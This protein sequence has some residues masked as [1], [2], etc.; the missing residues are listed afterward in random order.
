MLHSMPR[1]LILCEFPTLNGGERSLL[2]ALD[3][4]AAVEF[5]VGVIAPEEGPLAAAVHERGWELIPFA[6]RCGAGPRK[7]AAA[8]RGELRALALH[9]APAVIHANSLAMGRLLGPVA[10]ELGVPSLAHLRDIIG[11]SAQA[12]CDLNLNGRL[13]A[14]SHATRDFHLGQ[15]L[16]AA[17]TRV[18]Y[19]GVDLERFCPRPPTGALHCELGLPADAQLIGT[20]GQI[21]LRKGLDVLVAAAERIAPAIPRAHWVIVGERSS[22]KDES[23]RFEADL[24]AAAAEGPLAGRLHLLGRRGDVPALLCEW[25]MLVHAARQEPLGRVLLEA[26]ATGVPIAATAVGGTREIFPAECGAARLVPAGD[27]AAL[28]EAMAALLTDAELRRSLSQA[29]R[30]RAEA[31]FDIRTAAEGL[32]RHYAELADRR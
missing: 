30:R 25:T 23:R 17:K 9:R 1:L 3:A 11:L 18:L 21:G 6:T 27:A 10:A 15:G 13:L 22:D 7:S 16:D 5:E 24:R 29:A 32:R 20:V 14:V 19:N 4:G 8:L 12:V 2:A 31:Q 28:A 26:G